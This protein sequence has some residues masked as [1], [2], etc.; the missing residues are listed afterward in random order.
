MK[1]V[2]RIAYIALILP[3]ALSSCTSLIVPMATATPT[4]LPSNTP[5]P[6]STFTPQPTPTASLTFTPSPTATQ[7][8][9]PTPEIVV[10]YKQVSEIP[11]EDRLYSEGNNGKADKYDLPLKLGVIYEADLSQW[12]RRRL[13]NLDSW[14]GESVQKIYLSGVLMDDVVYNIEDGT[15][16]VPLGIEKPDGSLVTIYLKHYVG[17]EGD[18]YTFVGFDFITGIIGGRVGYY[19]GTAG[20]RCRSILIP[21]DVPV[22]FA[23]SIGRQIAVETIFPRNAEQL[24]EAFAFF[25]ASAEPAY[26]EMGVV[27]DPSDAVP[28]KR[29]YIFEETIESDLQLLAAIRN[30]TVEDG[31]ELNIFVSGFA[32]AWW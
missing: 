26:L 21:A 2:R 16:I 23:D 25:R 32:V 3:L 17:W 14:F 5:N 9:T 28:V 31:A 15:L 12:E 22:E 24:L 7:T 10:S 11:M 29:T 19:I 8:L 4:N 6:T 18:P 13:Q 1:Q 20:S 30:G 27:T